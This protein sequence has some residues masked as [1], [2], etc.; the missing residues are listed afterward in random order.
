MEILEIGPQVSRKPR[1]KYV[2]KE[3]DG[4]ITVKHYL[5]LK[6]KGKEINGKKLYPV[7]VQLTFSGKTFQYKSLLNAYIPEN[8]FDMFLLKNKELIEEE[9]RISTQTAELVRSNVKNQIRKPKVIELIDGGETIYAG[10]WQEDEILKETGKYLI[11][12]DIYVMTWELDNFVESMLK[13]NLACSFPLDSDLRS[14]ID[15]NNRSAK[16]LY[17]NIEKLVGYDK[18]PEITLTVASL[19]YVARNYKPKMF[20]DAFPL[21]VHW[22]D[23]S[24]GAYVKIFLDRVRPNEKDKR[25]GFLRV[26]EAMFFERENLGFFGEEGVTH[27]DP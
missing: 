19:Q 23:W 27:Y 22:C 5:H 25:L 4:K 9:V 13:F 2:K 14:M 18:F 7:Y 3:R 11:A 16:F 6:L 1:G 26:L 10:K 24:E 12:N 15:W 20:S 21:G 17:D 8:E